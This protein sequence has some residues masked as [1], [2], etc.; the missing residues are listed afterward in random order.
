MTFLRV[1]LNFKSKSGNSMQKKVYSIV[2][3]EQNI[4]TLKKDKIKL[5]DTQK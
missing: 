1:K 5:S 3:E 4:K 2:M